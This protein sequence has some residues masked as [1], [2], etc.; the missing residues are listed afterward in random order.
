MKIEPMETLQK[1]PK[2]NLIGITYCLHYLLQGVSIT[3]L[4]PIAPTISKVTQGLKKRFT[5]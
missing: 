5:R 1:N 4:T 3:P 2:R